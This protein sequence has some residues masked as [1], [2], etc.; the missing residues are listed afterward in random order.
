ML[1]QFKKQY[2]ISCA[3]PGATRYT[4]GVVRSGSSLSDAPER[5]QRARNET[6][7]LRAQRAR[8]DKNTGQPPGLKRRHERARSRCFLQHPRLRA[9]DRPHRT[10]LLTH[11]APFRHDPPRELL[12]D[13]NESSDRQGDQC[14]AELTHGRKEHERDSSCIKASRISRNNVFG[15]IVSLNSLRQ[16]VGGFTPDGPRFRGFAASTQD[17]ARDRP[18]PVPSASSQW[19]PQAASPECRRR[20]R[21]LPRRAA[22]HRTRHSPLPGWPLPSC[23]LHS[24]LQKTSPVPGARGQRASGAS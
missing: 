6:G 3:G 17:Y 21:G 7:D 15:E 1:V 9:D 2:Q 4:N 19:E 8:C 11:T 10:A 22:R 24:P 18:G 23:P 14:F 5:T 16:I 12:N 20:P 13:V